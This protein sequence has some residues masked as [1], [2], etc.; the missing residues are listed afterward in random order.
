MPIRGVLP[1]QRVLRFS[2]YATASITSFG[3]ISCAADP[4]RSTS[5]SPAFLTSVLINISA[6]RSRDLPR[7][8]NAIAWS[9]TEATRTCKLQSVAENESNDRDAQ[10][11][12]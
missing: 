11:D 9:T 2:S 3:S 5:E 12:S 6:T 1:E 8:T 10:D 4:V 7:N